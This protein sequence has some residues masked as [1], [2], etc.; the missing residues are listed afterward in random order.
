MSV[1]L[2][3]TNWCQFDDDCEVNL[4]DMGDGREAAAFLS[5]FINHW[6]PT[7]Q[8]VSGS[9]SMPNFPPVGPYDFYDSRIVNGIAVLFSITAYLL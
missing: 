6:S 9:L 7:D 3:D 2:I 1:P 4:F 5:M 8:K